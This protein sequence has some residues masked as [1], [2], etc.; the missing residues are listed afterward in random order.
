[1]C[2]TTQM[3]VLG[4]DHLQGEVQRAAFPLKLLDLIYFKIRTYRDSF[5]TFT[6]Q[7]IKLYIID[8]I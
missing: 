2:N 4:W 5:Y 7:L 6:N 3:G 8:L 1:M